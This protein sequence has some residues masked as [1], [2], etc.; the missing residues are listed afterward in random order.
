M[1]STARTAAG[2][3]TPTRSPGSI[4][5]EKKR[6]NVAANRSRSGPIDGGGARL[7]RTRQGE[8]DEERADGRRHLD[9]LRQARRR[10]A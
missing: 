8:T 2:T 3:R 10:A 9:L 5:K 4:E 1:P 6:K 7:D